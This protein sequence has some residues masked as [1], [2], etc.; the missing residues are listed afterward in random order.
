MVADEV[1]KV[2][3]P[4]CAEPY[5]CAAE[6]TPVLLMVN[7]PAANEVQMPEPLAYVV[8]ATHCGTPLFQVRIWPP[9][10]VP[11]KVEVAIATTL[12]VEPV[13]LTKTVLAPICAR[14]V[15]ATPLVAMPMVALVPPIWYPREPE[16][17]VK[18]PET[19]SEE[20]ATELRALVPLP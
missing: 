6:R 20:V 3:A 15:R 14:L 17:T 16:E 13:L 12:P 5:V 19:A 10:P 2:R 4:V 7:C 11:K 18:P 1:A 8:L 9:D